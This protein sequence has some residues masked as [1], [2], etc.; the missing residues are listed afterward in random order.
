MPLEE[1]YR[2]YHQWLLWLAYRLTGNWD[3]AGDVVHDVFLK[4]VG[5]KETIHSVKSWLAKSVTNCALDYKRLAWFRLRGYLKDW[6][7]WP[8]VSR[9]SFAEQDAINHILKKLTP[10]ERAVM[11]LRDME[12]Y[13]VK[14]IA[15]T[16]HVAQATV[17]VLSKTGRDKFIRLYTEEFAGERDEN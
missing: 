4:L 14:E 3:T 5:K 8:G 2:Q 13:P 9:D 12:G 15:E 7:R 16:L 10:K 11:V 1:I 17:R 6:E